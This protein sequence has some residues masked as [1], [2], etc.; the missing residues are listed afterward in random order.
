MRPSSSRSTAVRVE[1]VAVV[2]GVRDDPAVAVLPGLDEVAGR[3]RDE[4]AGGVALEGGPA[5]QRVVDARQPAGGV[6][7]RSD[8]RAPSGV[9]IA[10]RRP[11]ASYSQATARPSRV[12]RTSWP[13]RFHSSDV[14]DGAAVGAGCGR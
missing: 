6:V 5:E 2:D 14:L 10:V 8:V 1:P 7:A 12:R 3:G 9:V 11:S 4:A 13:R